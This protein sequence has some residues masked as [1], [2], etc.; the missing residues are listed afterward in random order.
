LAIFSRNQK[1]KFEGG[2]L[3][4]FQEV[5]QAMAVE[6]MLKAA[7]YMVR[8]VAPPPELRKGC[9]L[10]VEINLVEQPGIER[11][12]KEKDMAYTS[13]EPVRAKT[14]PLLDAVKVTDFGRWVMVKAG[15]MKITYEKESG[16][17]VNVSGGGCPDI[18]YL[19]T[20]LIDKRLDQAPRPKAL[21]F[22]LCALNLER[23]LDEC[24]TLYS[25]GNKT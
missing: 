9:D 18:P 12:L 3:V 13:I 25:G 14:A 22:T 5:S 17:I 21:G 1:A 6:K 16:V 4:L 8:L 2:G 23:A 15:N 7:G 24:L 11:L 10:A 20:E 19:H